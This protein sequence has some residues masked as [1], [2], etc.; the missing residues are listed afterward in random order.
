[1]IHV[2]ID[3]GLRRLSNSN[4]VSRIYYD[5]GI[6]LPVKLDKYLYVLIIKC[7]AKLQNKSEPRFKVNR[8]SMK[9]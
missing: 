1:M 7:K 4:S 2:L 9:R 3:L 8:V 5:K 6:N